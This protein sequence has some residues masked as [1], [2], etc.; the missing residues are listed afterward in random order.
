MNQYITSL[1]T[2]ELAK[3]NLFVSQEHRQLFSDLLNCYIES[4]FFHKGLCKCM[5]LSC[6][7]LEH[8]TIMLDI[9]NNMTIEKSTDTEEMSENGQYLENESEGYDRYIYQLS[10]AFLNNEEFTLPDEP[11]QEEGMNIIKHAL[12]AAKIID[13]IFE[14]A[15]V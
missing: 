7:D 13:R 12:K 11:I 15:G 14:E 1:C 9:L 8:Y 5:Y 6:W 10:G 3:E 2:K 4:P